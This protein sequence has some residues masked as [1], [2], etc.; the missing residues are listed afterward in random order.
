METL[1]QSLRD[2]KLDRNAADAKILQIQE[3]INQKQEVDL[4][5]ATTDAERLKIDR[6]IDTLTAKANPYL[7]ISDGR[8][9]YAALHLADVLEATQPKDSPPSPENI[10]E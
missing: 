5:A 6:E 2:L 9:V 10:S 8:A 4:P 1:I 3:A 7:E